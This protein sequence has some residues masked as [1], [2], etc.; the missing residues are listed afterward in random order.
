[1]RMLI[2]ACAVALSCLPV[3]AQEVQC[4]EKDLAIAQM[5]IEGITFLGIL[6]APFTSEQMFFA[7]QGGIVAAFPMRGDCVIVDVIVLGKMVAQVGV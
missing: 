6:P 5:E 3:A 1:M 7:E 4:L 2:A